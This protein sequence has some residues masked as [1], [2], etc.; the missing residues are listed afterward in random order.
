M[1]KTFSYLLVLLLHWNPRDWNPNFMNHLQ[2]KLVQIIGRFEKSGVKLQYL[3][4][5]GKLQL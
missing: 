1:C 2:S 3:T 4:S 5:K